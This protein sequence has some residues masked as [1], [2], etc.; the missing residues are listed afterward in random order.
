MH[1]KNRHDKVFYV[2][3]KSYFCIDCDGEFV[4]KEVNHHTDVICKTNKYKL[5]VDIIDQKL[6]HLLRVVKRIV[7]SEENNIYF[8]DFSV[9]DINEIGSKYLDR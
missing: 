6:D 9:Q 8:K 4:G 7:A 1:T 2:H 3:K 5:Q